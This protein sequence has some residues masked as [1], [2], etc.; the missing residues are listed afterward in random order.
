MTDSG[1]PGDIPAN[2]TIYQLLS[3]WLF[4][5]GFNDV[6][7]FSILATIAYLGWYTITTAIP[8]HLE[9]IQNGYDR[10]TDRLTAEHDRDRATF[11][12]AID[13]ADARCDMHRERPAKTEAKTADIAE[14]QP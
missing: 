9:I 7:L 3:R 10:I 4:R 11:E 12:K 13:R 5:Q 8:S 14:K 2:T 1:E 6:L